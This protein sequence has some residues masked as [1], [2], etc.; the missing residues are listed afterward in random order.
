M[1][2]VVRSI[3]QLA[4]A[5][6]AAAWLGAAVVALAVPLGIPGALLIAAILLV[7][8]TFRALQLA[9]LIG[10]AWIWHWPVV[11]ALLFAAPRL[12]LILP[13]LISTFLANR[14]HPRLRWS[15]GLISH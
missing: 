5:A 3:L 8:R 9:A 6:Y 10:A 1:K 2:W 13:G 4:A 15:S 14:R 7:S 11:L 12:L